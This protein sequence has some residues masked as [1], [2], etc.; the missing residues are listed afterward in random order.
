M[1]RPNLL[2]I[3]FVA[4][5]GGR[6]ATTEVEDRTNLGWKTKLYLGEIVIERADGDKLAYVS[7]ETVV[8][9]RA[10]PDTESLD[11]HQVDARDE[12]RMTPEIRNR[13]RRAGFK[14]TEPNELVFTFE[15]RGKLSFC[16]LALERVEKI[17]EAFGAYDL[18]QAV[19]KSRDWIRKMEIM[20]QT[21]VQRKD[22]L[23][24]Q[25]LNE[26]LLRKRG[27]WWE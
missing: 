25:P 3:T 19:P 20:T 9:V 21:Y 1:K 14:E 13:M 17:A 16:E 26:H 23:P 24:L 8:G 22:P 4:W 5:K 7:L 27:H 18:D 6:I 12:Y 15:V 10:G 2:N 11:F